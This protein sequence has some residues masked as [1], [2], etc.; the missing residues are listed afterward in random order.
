MDNMSTTG[1]PLRRF[2]RDGNRIIYCRKC[3]EPI[4][5]NSALM[6]FGSISS[7]VLCDAAERGEVL[8]DNII[9]EIKSSRLALVSNVP[10]IQFL[11]ADAERA[12]E[13]IALDPLRKEKE[14]N[15]SSTRSRFRA[16][17]IK[18][19]ETF[20]EKITK[21]SGAQKLAREKRRKRIFDRPIEDI[22]ED[23]DK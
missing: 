15:I 22:L 9:S 7:C 21:T 10:G 17:G 23:E 1:L 4:G 5:L 19:I 2:N 11:T 20:K 14:D 3:H 18:I 13:A 12:Q 16:A 8:P 6:N